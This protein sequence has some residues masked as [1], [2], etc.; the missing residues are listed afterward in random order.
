M[1]GKRRSATLPREKPTHQRVK[2]SMDSFIA[3]QGTEPGSGESAPS[4]ANGSP[5]GPQFGVAGRLGLDDRDR[6][7]S[8]PIAKMKGR[9]EKHEKGEKGKL[10]G[11]VKR[12]STNALKDKYKR[13]SVEIPPPVPALPHNFSPTSPLTRFDYEGKAKDA[14]GNYPSPVSLTGKKQTSSSHVKRPSTAPALTTEFPSGR[15]VV[16]KKQSS[17][18]N[19]LLAAAGQDGKLTTITR[20]SSPFS[21]DIASSDSFN[22]MQSNR[23]SASSYGDILLGAGERGPRT[24]KPSLGQHIMPPEKLFMLDDLDLSF[25]GFNDGETKNT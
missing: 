17:N 11:L 16:R 22:R 2:M 15:F 3:V 8:D 12:I 20:S 18:Q 6:S 1:S 10:W 23:S 4:A 25:G 19:Q 24:H 5:V 21:S 14:S 13:A 7:V 9:Y